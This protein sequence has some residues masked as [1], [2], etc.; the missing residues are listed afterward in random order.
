MVRQV[1]LHLPGELPNQRANAGLDRIPAI[2]DVHPREGAPF[3]TPPHRGSSTGID[4]CSVPPGPFGSATESPARQ[5]SFRSLGRPADASG[6]A[7]TAGIAAAGAGALTVAAPLVLMAVA[8]GV[9]AHA[10]QKQQQANAPDR[11]LCPMRTRQ[12][13]FDAAGDNPELGEFAPVVDL[14]RRRPRGGPYPRHQQHLS[15]PHH[16]SAAHGQQSRR[17]G[18]TAPPH[19]CPRAPQ[20]WSDHDAAR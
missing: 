18:G 1:L 13:A 16:T 10:E 19:R 15:S 2:R 7:E 12:C 14:S 4:H 20:A 17:T 3:P 9:S 6:S 11:S 8:V 5:R